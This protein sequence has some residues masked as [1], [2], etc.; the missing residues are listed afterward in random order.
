MKNIKKKGIVQREVK[1]TSP[2][3]VNY[4]L[5]DFGKEEVI[6]FIPV[7]VNFL[8]P[9]RYKKKFRGINEIHESVRASINP[10][11]IPKEEEEYSTEI[12]QKAI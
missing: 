1:A 4:T 11:S 12:S 8:L 7:L 5:S 9:P 3:R 10:E 2:P 6:L